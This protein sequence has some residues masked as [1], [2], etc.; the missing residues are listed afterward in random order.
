MAEVK[1]CENC[2]VKE[3]TT[4]LYEGKKI[5]KSLCIECYKTP[6]KKPGEKE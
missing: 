5:V 2:K 6:Y 4:F 3:A 1:M